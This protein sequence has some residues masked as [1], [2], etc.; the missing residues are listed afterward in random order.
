MAHGQNDEPGDGVS[1]REGVAENDIYAGSGFPNRRSDKTP[2][3]FGIGP[4]GHSAHPGNSVTIRAMRRDI[5]YNVARNQYRIMR[6]MAN[7]DTGPNA[8]TIGRTVPLLQTA[9]PGSGVAEARQ[10]NRRCGT[11]IAAPIAAVS[12]FV[13]ALKHSSRRQRH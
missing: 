10:V 13:G 12:R 8:G 6:R 9:R 1:I 5:N 11:T 4:R 2:I 7:A 3:Q